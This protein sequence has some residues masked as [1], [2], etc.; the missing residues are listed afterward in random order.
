[1]NH[2][3]DHLKVWRREPGEVCFNEGRGPINFRLRWRK[4]GRGFYLAIRVF[5]RWLRVTMGI[6][7]LRDYTDE[8]RQL[9]GSMVYRSERHR[10]GAG[11]PALAELRDWLTSQ[12]VAV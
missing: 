1:M 9:L 12:G 8:Q 3:Y 7:R 4:P 6:K 5:G 11:H 10:L 2:H